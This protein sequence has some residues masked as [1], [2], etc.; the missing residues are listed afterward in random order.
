M[1]GEQGREGAKALR[2]SFCLG[3]TLMGASEEGS[4]VEMVQE[5]HLV[6]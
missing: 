6:R 3:W 1:R 2:A 5:P 4:W